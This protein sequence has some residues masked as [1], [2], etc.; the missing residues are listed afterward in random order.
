MDELAD[1]GYVIIDHFLSAEELQLI[2]HYLNQL[3]QEDQLQKAGIGSI[4][5]HVD[6]EIRGDFI[7]WL[8]PLKDPIMSPYFD[9]VDQLIELLNRYCF[10]SIS[11]SEF[12]FALY[13][14]GSFYQKHLDQFKERNN[15]LISMVFYMN[16]NW[17]PEDEGELM[18]YQTEPPIKI[19][20]INNRLVM[21]KSD[22]VEHEVLLTHANRKSIT[23]WLLHQPNGL[24]YLT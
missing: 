10:L 7:Y 4:D 17:K 6:K 14:K 12:H 11:S 15:R 3:D 20:P 2:A 24:G 22:S 13:P 9:K 21:F 16:E 5:Y 23:G 19:P 18:I 8:S 1:K